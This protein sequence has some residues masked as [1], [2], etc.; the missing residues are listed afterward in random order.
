VARLYADENFPLPA[1]QELRKLGYDVLTIHEAGLSG[2]GVSDEDV[3]SAALT[4]QRA[5]LTLNRK[6][7]MQLHRER[8]RHAGVVVCTFD[9]DF[10]AL[11]RRIDAAIGVDSDIAGRLIRI[12]RPG[13]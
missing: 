12:T 8:P 9:S 3:F 1:I 2:L 4:D 11:A 5:I 10:V 6:H 7:F 13:P